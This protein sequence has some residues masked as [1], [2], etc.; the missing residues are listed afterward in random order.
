V[1]VL[2][3]L[4]SSLERAAET[5]LEIHGLISDNA[6]TTT[7]RAW[8][9]SMAAAFTMLCTRPST[10]EAPTASAPATAETGTTAAPTTPRRK[11]GGRARATPAKPAAS[12]PAATAKQP[13]SGR[14][15]ATP[16]RASSGSG[17]GGGHGRGA[18]TILT[19]HLASVR[20]GSA[21]D[22]TDVARYAGY[23]DLNNI[24]V[25]TVVGLPRGNAPA[26]LASCPSADTAVQYARLA[27]VD[28]DAALI[29]QLR[30]A[31]AQNAHAEAPPPPPGD[32]GGAGGARD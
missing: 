21:A 32:P 22:P 5:R 11:R 20:G 27:H 29:H 18:S 6:H 15:H 25:N 3:G 17:R 12:A 1:A 16:G 31:W 14:A 19:R 28:E 23:L 7:A 24:S 13:T 2:D 4:G 9:R 30:A 8:E 26:R 10:R